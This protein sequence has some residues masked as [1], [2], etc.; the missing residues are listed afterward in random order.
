[1]ENDSK[2]KEDYWLRV[3]LESNNEDRNKNRKYKFGDV[4]YDKIADRFNVPDVILQQ[5]PVPGRTFLEDKAWF[6]DYASFDVYENAL[7]LIS[8]LFL[9]RYPNARFNKQG[10][11]DNIKKLLTS[12]NIGVGV[13]IEARSGKV[14]KQTTGK[15]RGGRTRR[16][17][18]T[19]VRSYKSTKEDTPVLPVLNSMS[20]TF[21]NVSQSFKEQLKF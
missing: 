8:N 10:C 11:I 3:W 1:M 7:R 13:K 5:H 16:K 9:M 19:L 2:G 14:D 15:D 6:G 12:L 20:S 21:T 17:R 4:Y 18:K